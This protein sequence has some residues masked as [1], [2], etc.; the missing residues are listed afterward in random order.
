MICWCELHFRATVYFQQISAMFNPNRT[1]GQIW[2]S[3]IG[4]N[5][6]GQAYLIFHIF[7]VFLTEN[8]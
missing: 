5:V 6:F 2:F 3:N 1:F 4:P 7:F 8:N